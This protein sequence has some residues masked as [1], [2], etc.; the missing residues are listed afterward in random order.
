MVSGVARRS[1]PSRLV[2]IAKGWLVFYLLLVIGPLGLAVYY[3]VHERD[4]RGG[5]GP[6]LSITGWRDAALEGRVLLRSF[7]LASANTA[8]TVLLG[9]PVAFGLSRVTARLRRI[10]VLLLIVPMAVNGLLVAYAWQVLLATHG[11]L[12]S[13]LL[14]IGLVRKPLDVLFGPAAV[15]IGLLGTYLPIFVVVFL[16]S[17][18]ATDPGYSIASQALGASPFKTLL[19]VTI[20]LARP[21]LLT[22]ALLVFL[23]SFAEYTIPDILGG[24]REFLLGNLLQYSFFGGRNWPL[25]SALFVVTVVGLG[26]VAGYAAR[27][28]E[29]AFLE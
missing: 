4:F 29:G 21:G 19:H 11:P 25:G 9:G 2:L 27:Y 6:G 22:G 18:A 20:P 24:G 17:L 10:S 5:V 8:L 16:G 3:S 28:L 1:R 12:N 7:A 14:A 23:P 15:L 13:T 26:L